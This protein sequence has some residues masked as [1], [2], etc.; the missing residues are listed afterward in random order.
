MQTGGGTYLGEQSKAVL[1]RVV[2]LRPTTGSLSHLTE[3]CGGN[4]P[5]AAVQRWKKEVGEGGPFGEQ[6]TGTATK[7]KGKG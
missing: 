7:H 3:S 4:R 2:Y 1:R 6:A 5:G